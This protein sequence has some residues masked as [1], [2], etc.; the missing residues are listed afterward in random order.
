M[1]AFQLT[2]WK[3]DP[4]LREVP[5]PQ[6]GPGEVVIRVAA[7]GACHSDLHLMHDFE[8]GLLPWGPPFTLG[9]ETTGWVE[10]LGDGVTGVE[11]GEPVAVYGPWG[12]G[13]CSRCRQGMENYCEAA[14]EIGAAGGGLGLDGG[15]APLMR[16][17]SPRL[18]IPLGDL[19]PV[20]AAP[21]T[22]AGLTP[23]HGIA[24]SRHLLVPGSTAVVIGAG[25][26]G[27]MAVQILK[28]TTSATV[29]AVDQH[30]GA[31][32]LAA[33]LGADH[34][35]LSGDSAVDEVRDLTGGKGADLVLDVVGVDATLA[36]AAAVSRTLG[37][38]TILGIGGGTLPITFFS[39]PYEVSVATTYWGSSVELGE[40]VA[41]ARAGHVKAHVERIA[42]DD[43]M[44]AY[45]RMQDGTLR[46]RAVI[47]P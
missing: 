4:E 24:R 40:V 21:L 18:L 16:V 26:L 47:V 19:D 25:G 13:R 9:H 28:A 1:K 5:E 34:G 38:L 37:H 8:A 29:I 33:D 42:L 2:A 36:L 41:L 20:E 15:M 45:T 43:A 12:C 44:T 11:V 32:D 31:L 10:T 30:Q 39:L 22:D 6:A 46:G 14:A 7:S 23:Y 17:P 27:H 35:V 3:H